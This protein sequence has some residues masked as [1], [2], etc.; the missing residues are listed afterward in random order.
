M[1]RSSTTLVSGSTDTTLTTAPPVANVNGKYKITSA[2]PTADSET[3]HCTAPVTCAGKAEPLVTQSSEINVAT[4]TSV[5]LIASAT[6]VCEEGLRRRTFT[7]KTR[8]KVS[9]PAVGS[10]L[11]SR[12][13]TTATRPTTTCPRYTEIIPATAVNGVDTASCNVAS[14]F[15]G[16]GRAP[17]A[18]SISRP[19]SEA[20]VGRSGNSKE[21]SSASCASKSNRNTIPYDLGIDTTPMPCSMPTVS[22]ISIPPASSTTNGIL[23][24]N[25]QLTLTPTN[26]LVTPIITPISTSL[27]S[28][29]EQIDI[30][31]HLGTTSISDNLP[32][33]ISV[34]TVPFTPI[35]PNKPVEFI[36]TYRIE[37]KYDSQ[38]TYTA[39]LKS[40]L[41]STDR[42][43]PETKSSTPMTSSKTITNAATD[44]NLKS[45]TTSSPRCNILQTTSTKL[46]SIASVPFIRVPIT[47]NVCTTVPPTTT[48]TTPSHTTPRI[49]SAL[50]SLDK[51]HN[52]LVTVRS[53]AQLCQQCY[54][55]LN[56]VTS[57]PTLCTLVGSSTYVE[58]IS[59]SVKASLNNATIESDLSDPGDFQST[60]T[61]INSSEGRYLQ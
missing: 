26:D 23:M 49:S 21:N 2:A 16:N 12:Q 36:S 44:S 50:L 5:Q 60:R 58:S 27:V 11:L 3:T 15:Q 48:F 33:P 53:G 25:E 39:I 55:P 20:T 41:S 59:S 40:S 14:S 24:D 19:T 17:S 51:P 8:S 1:E 57:Q 7:D 38:N 54:D 28:C 6:R 13:P 47:T 42:S 4:P 31:N 35:T 56:A 10:T 46:G 43:T 32:N 37:H 30:H 29:P 9:S 18:A 61:T 22:N 34:A 45:T 52:E